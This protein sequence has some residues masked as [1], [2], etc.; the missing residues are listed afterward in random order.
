MGHYSVYCF[1]VERLIKILSSINSHS[2]SVLKLVFVFRGDVASCIVYIIYNAIP[3]NWYK[4]NIATA[5]QLQYTSERNKAKIIRCSC[6]PCIEP[7]HV[8]HDSFKI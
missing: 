1:D 7:I 5:E 2:K 4:L 8:K 6:T 3:P